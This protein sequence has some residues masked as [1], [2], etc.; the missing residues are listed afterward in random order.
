MSR[1]LEP[2]REHA[3]S[4]AETPRASRPLSDLCYLSRSRSF[5]PLPASLILSC[6]PPLFC[7]CMVFF[8][9]FLF[10]SSFVFST[11]L[12]SG[13]VL[14]SYEYVPVFSFSYIQIRIIR[15][16]VPLFSVVFTPFFVSSPK[17]CLFFFFQSFFFLFSDVFFSM[18]CFQLSCLLCKTKTKRIES[19]RLLS[20]LSLFPR[21]FFSFFCFSLR[22]V[23]CLLCQMKTKTKRLSCFLFMRRFFF[24]AY[25]GC[26][27]KR[28]RKRH[29]SLSCLVY[30]CLPQKRG[31]KM[32]RRPRRL[33]GTP[34]KFL[35]RA[36]RSPR[37]GN[38]VKMR[39]N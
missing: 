1:V 39:R 15:T 6:F 22:Y 23:S 13:F 38:Y 29:A 17:L 8:S 27:A 34:S 30:T 37:W 5:F 4:F 33:R 10:F 19:K 16:V 11:L 21:H 2:T 26:C 9:L 28:K 7:F 20:F 36:T 14:Y 32:G 35:R 3:P 18:F 31:K 12:F 24:C 25:L